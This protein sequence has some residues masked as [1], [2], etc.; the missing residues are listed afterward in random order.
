MGDRTIAPQGGASRC[1][2]IRER[3][4]LH[5]GRQL[6]RSA[7]KQP[8]ERDGPPAAGDAAGTCGG[9]RPPTAPPRAGERRSIVGDALEVV[10]NEGRQ[11][12]DL[13]GLLA[14]DLRRGRGDAVRDPDLVEDAAVHKPL[15]A[16]AGEDPV[17]HEAGHL[18]GAQL[19]QGGAG[20]HQRA[21][22]LHEVVED[23]AVALLGR[24]LLDLDD[25]LVSLADLAAE[26]LGEL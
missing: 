8:A 5:N 14:G 19:L 20:L 10:G 17:R 12:Q 26:D 9:P 6:S 23:D 4:G 3:G 22:A 18:A 13:E 16:G 21:A 24:A 1:R 7:V 25:P 11:R 15:P 2:L